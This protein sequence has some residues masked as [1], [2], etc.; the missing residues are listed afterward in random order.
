MLQRPDL[1]PWTPFSLCLLN[2]G[3]IF[4]L[5]VLASVYWV[6]QGLGFYLFS[7]N[8]FEI[9][10]QWGVTRFNQCFLIPDSILLSALIR[11]P[12]LWTPFTSSLVY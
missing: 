10:S 4:C 8:E 1:A 2:D 3:F 11:T 5:D 7:I 12:W 6:L 9:L